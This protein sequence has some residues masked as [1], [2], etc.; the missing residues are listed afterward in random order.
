MISTFQ[1][2]STI[3][4]TL[5][6]GGSACAAAVPKLRK[7]VSMHLPSRFA[8]ALLSCAFA[9]ASFSAPP[10][11]S[12][13]QSGKG[14]GESITEPNAQMP[15][16]LLGPEPG[17]GDRQAGPGGDRSDANKPA[18]HQALE[19]GFPDTPK[20]RRKVLGN[21]YAHLAAAPDAQTANQVAQV[22]E[23]IWVTPGSDTVAVLMERAAAALNERN[24]KLAVEFLDAVVALAPDYAEGWNRR[25]LAYF[26]DADYTRSMGDLRRVLALEPNHFKA[27]QGLAQILK[28]MGQ[29]KGAMKAYRQLLEVHPFAEGGE[30]A[31]REVERKVEGQGI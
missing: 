14:A 20:K 29:E 15:D 8:F 7:P 26:M 11:M 24:T 1:K 23:R 9:F 28:D 21:L 22:I 4:H 31:L 5:V 17:G 18:F 10:A 2:T 6:A 30:E 12:A 13:D 25:A 3:A 27:L 19:D 16:G